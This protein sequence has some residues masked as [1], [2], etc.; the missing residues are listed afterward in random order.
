M[1]RRRY[2]AA[3]ASG[4]LAGCSHPRHDSTPTVAADTPNVVQILVDDLGWADVGAYQELVPEED[5]PPG[6][7]FHETPNVDRL[8]AEGTLFTDGYAASPICSPTRASLYTGQATPRHGITDR[9]D[10]GVTKGALV[11]PRSAST[12][13]R[14]TPTQARLLRRAGYRTIHLGK[15]HVSEKPP[16][17]RPGDVG[18]ET[19][20]AGFH[21][22]RPRQ[23]YVCPYGMPGLDCSGEEYLTRRLT[24][25]AVE[26]IE[27]VSADRPFF[28]NLA[29]YSVHTPI[30]APDPVVDR[31]RVK[32]RAMGL[33]EGPVTTDGQRTVQS[34][35]TYAAMIAEMDRAVGRVLDAI[36]DL[37]RPTIVLFH[38]DNGGLATVGS[39]SPTSSLPLER[40]KGWP[41]EGGIRVPTIVR[42]PGMTGGGIERTPVVTQDLYTTALGAAGVDLPD[43]DD[44]P[45]DGV[46]LRPL[47]AGEGLDDRAIGFH[48][49]HYAV[50]GSTP[51]GAIRR[52]PYKLIE[53]FEDGHV[54]LYNV[55]E[56]PGETVELSR[57]APR[58]AE[59]LRHALREWRDDV[60]ARMPTP[61]PDF[62]GEVSP[63]R[64]YERRPA[65]SPLVDS[66]RR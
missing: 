47:L 54:E 41:H 48:Y 65:S 43:P 56:D 8:A 37:E 55:A 15:W 13:P 9:H 61:N 59:E 36:D 1:R 16:D 20:V 35:A 52:G 23:G 3:L 25:V 14:D 12:V 6:Y 32:R 29:F 18:F 22:G 42:W 57:A 17:V 46:D 63:G 40:G 28:L 51:A 62:E 33:P 49:P 60:G 11:S 19:N 50:Q 7:G 26:R 66:G 10:T 64:F 31:F 30:E 38:S 21:W 44:H 34:N 53:F 27:D 5:R 45:V 4:A 2:L 39:R 58:L 24:E